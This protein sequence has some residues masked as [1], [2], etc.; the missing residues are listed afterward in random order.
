MNALSS[1]AESELVK[2][3]SDETGLGSFTSIPF[4]PRQLIDLIAR[5]FGTLYPFA[6]DALR[7]L[8][9]KARG[10]PPLAFR[11]VIYAISTLGASPEL[12]DFQ[13]L[14]SIF[15]TDKLLDIW[16]EGLRKFLG[17]R[18]LARARVILETLLED[19][20]V[21]ESEVCEELKLRPGA[22]SV[23]L[24]QLEA[25]HFVRRLRLRTNG[26]GIVLA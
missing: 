23:L 5:E 4:E 7:S 24:D 3:N 15:P 9:V 18:S 22:V 21:C 2:L 19:G 13:K 1:W 10:R 6:P 16:S 11:L 26:K 14:E 8:T 12:I 17:K 20:V 25:Q